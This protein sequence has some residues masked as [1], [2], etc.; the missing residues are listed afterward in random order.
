VVLLALRAAA[1]ADAN[2]LPPPG[3]WPAPVVGATNPLLGSPFT[4][5]GGYASAQASLRVWLP[6]GRQRRAAITQTI[7]RRTVVRGRLR[8]RIS[9]RSISGAT[10][11]LATQNVEGAEWYLVGVARTNRKGRFRAL[12]P[13]GPTRRAAVLYWPFASSLTPVYSKR[14]LVRA[15]ARVS[16]RISARGRSALFRGTV[17]GD[18]IPAGG[19]VVAAQVRNGDAW[20]SVRLVRTDA[21]GR[22]RA[23]YRFKYRNRRFVVR[24]TAPSQPGWRLYSGSSGRRSIR[25]R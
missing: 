9:R 2:L 17:S 7:G 3:P 19:L 21:N 15:S 24:A 1:T 16:L 18:V 8:D 20:V 11:Q 23:R 13:A 5:N 12:L 10:V 14:L 25:T 4:D 6:S 22:F